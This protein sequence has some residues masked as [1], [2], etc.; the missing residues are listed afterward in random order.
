MKKITDEQYI[1]LFVS[2]GYIPLSIPRSSTDKIECV[3]KYGYR[4]L[5]SYGALRSPNTKNLAR[6]KKP[7]PFKPQNMRL[8][9]SLEEPN[10]MILTPDNEL[11]D[12]K[13]KAIMFACPVC[14]QSF[15]ARW[16]HYTHMKRKWCPSCNK[17]KAQESNKIPFEEIVN[18]YKN[19]N[20]VLLS[21]ESDYKNRCTRLHCMDEKGYKFAVKLD[22]VRSG[23]FNGIERYAVTNP[24][25][26]ENLRHYITLNKINA[27]ALKR[28][29][30][31]VWRFECSCGDM[32]DMGLTNFLKGCVRCPKCV[33]TDSQY[34]LA[35]REWLDENN[36]PYTKE[37]RFDD[38]RHKK[39]LPFDFMI[40]K[41]KKEVVLI[42][43]DGQQH[44]YTTPWTS[45]E[46]LKLQQKRDRI[47]DRYCKNNNYTLIRIPFWKINS[48]TYKDI[49]TQTLLA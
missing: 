2:R 26:L 49:L 8:Y 6:F 19:A 34:S 3:D 42:E 24:F 40:E 43:V 27:V 14:K 48:G 38:C 20:L 17:S 47:K 5:G 25:A 1:E 4:Y 21:K 31:R 46:D 41:K 15:K 28:L 16:E 18:L 33:N 7:N 29:N 37:Y 23:I 13:G 36:I 11:I 9:V 32:F 35:V 39:P 12:T 45:E 22:S 30:Q 44:F 10:S